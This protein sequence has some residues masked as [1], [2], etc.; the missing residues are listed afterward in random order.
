M[1]DKK[2]QIS[3]SEIPEEIDEKELEGEVLED[4]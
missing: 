2:Y 4:E 1:E 3:T